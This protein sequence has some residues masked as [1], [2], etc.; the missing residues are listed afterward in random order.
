MSDEPAGNDS[1]SASGEP[2]GQAESP[3]SSSDAG[4]AAGGESQRRDEPGAE[5][6]AESERSTP[7]ELVAGPASFSEGPASFSAGPAFFTSPAGAMLVATETAAAA[8]EPVTPTSSAADDAAEQRAQESPLATA[9]VAPEAAP[10]DWDDRQLCIDGGCIG[11]LDRSGACR[12]CGKVD[13]G[14]KAPAGRSAAPRGADGEGGVED[15]EDSDEGDEGGSAAA[16]GSAAGGGD[17]SGSGDEWDERKLCEDGACIGVVVG[18][19]CTTCGRA[20]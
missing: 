8:E 11:V 15:S 12:V 5:R 10:D 3:S 19:R 13:P 14:F 17:G 18:G 9:F 4:S 7:D 16:S 1:A 2:S 6:E 20:G